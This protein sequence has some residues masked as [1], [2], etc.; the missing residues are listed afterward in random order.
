[1]A[2]HDKHVTYTTY[3]RVD[4]LLEL[5]T[6]L[7]DGPEHDELLFIT[8]HQVY[9]LWFKQILHEAEAL[10]TA[11]E[12]GDTARAIALMGRIR[13]IVKTCVSQVDVL[14]T[15]TPLQF[16]SFRTRLASAS[17]FQSAQFRELEAVLG[18]R[19]RAGENATSGSGMAM[20]EHLTP[21]SPARARVEAAMSRRSLWDSVLRYFASRGHAIPDSVL[22]RDPST[23][24]E[25]S[26]DV[27]A[28]LVEMYRSDDQS[29]AVA[30]SLTDID[31]GIAEWRYRHVMMVQRTIGHKIGTGGS[32]GVGYLR[33]TLFQPAFTDLWEMR[34]QL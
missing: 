27:Q 1:M 6:P 29:R 7:S 31:E 23:P 13:T 11:L 28:A 26:P 34:S 4:E 12:G 33:S 19:D 10:Q 21:G 14:E 5:Q 30:E 9:E 32:S 24:Y 20:A 25:P 15:M 18:R 8:I 16:Q 3:L 22:H 2:T 17:G